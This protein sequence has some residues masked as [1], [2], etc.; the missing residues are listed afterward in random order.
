MSPEILAAL[1]Q[2]KRLC[3]EQLQ[4]L[5]QKQRELID[6]DQ[7]TRLLDLLSVKQ[8]MLFEL[9]KV[10]VALQPFARQ[11]PQERNWGNPQQRQ[12]C[13]AD[14]EVCER[15]LAQIVVQQKEDE[16]TLIRRRDEVAQALRGMHVAGLA[17]EAYEARTPN[18][19]SRIDLSSDVQERKP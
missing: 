19:V 1:V 13:A 3:L 12:R 4:V 17:R 8:R 5:G 10:D 2:R 11:S 6:S 15:L 7:V 14:L 16:Q 18:P 9:R